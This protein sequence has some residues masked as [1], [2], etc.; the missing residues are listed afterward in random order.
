MSPPH[1][2]QSGVS[3]VDVFAVGSH[4]EL[5]HWQFRIG[6]W[7]SWP[8]GNLG[9]VVPTARHVV[10][11]TLDRNWESLGGILV[12]PPRAVMFGELNDIILAFALGT[13][14]ALWIKEFYKGSWREWATYYGHT[15]NSPPHAVRWQSERYAVFALGTDSAVW[16]T[17]GDSWQSLGGAFS[18]APYAVTTSN[19]IHVFAADMQ[20]ALKHCSWNGNSWSDWES[21]GGILMSPP[22]ANVQGGDLM[23]VFAVGTDSAI[24]RRRWLGDSWTDWHLLGGTSTSPPATVARQPSFPVGEIVALGTD[25]AVWHLEEGDS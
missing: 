7:T 2:V 6:A 1:A 19:H 22:A 16:Y 13:D 9:R 15:L 12:T 10:P 3:S 14:H 18:S 4:S 23:H 17:M 20:S 25:H 11:P 8:I 24:W 5:L 21:L